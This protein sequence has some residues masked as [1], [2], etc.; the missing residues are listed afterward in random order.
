MQ[1]ASASPPSSL[2]FDWIM[3]VLAVVLMGGVVQ[4]GW[5]HGHGLVD[6]NFL[7][8]WHAILYGTMVLNGL[9]LG[10]MLAIN[11]SRRYELSRALP[12]GYWMSLAGV[13]IFALGGAFDLWWHTRYGIEND[14]NALISPS[15]LWLALGGALVFTGPLRSIAARYGPET[16]GWRITGP[17]IWSAL[18]LLTLLGFFT[19]YAQPIGDNT[20]FS[21]M[22]QHEAQT[23]GAL[24]RPRRRCARDAAAHHEQQR[25]LGRGGFTRWKARGF[26]RRP[27]RRSG[28]RYLRR[29]CGWL[30]SAP[31]NALRPARYA[32]SVVARRQTHRV[33]FHS[34]WNVRKLPAAN[35][36]G[37]RLGSANAGESNY[38]TAISNVVAR[39]NLNR[40][41]ITQWS[42]SANCSDPGENCKRCR[43]SLA[44]RYGRRNPAGMGSRQ[45][46]RI[47]HS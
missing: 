32:A 44:G 13:I 41:S 24:Y 38:R 27:R 45:P 20:E 46:D 7:T 5:A 33:C 25:Y 21:V 31:R 2:T 9:V 8:P 23:G 47:R 12:F 4:D 10:T 26:S 39:R 15:H 19:Q 28:F 29:K 14:I 16:G 34:R 43:A 36:N 11:L 30:A 22:Q 42:A 35:G 1:R 3:A 18:A 6:Q 37:R 40:L 17:V